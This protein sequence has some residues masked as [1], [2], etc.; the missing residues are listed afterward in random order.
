MPLFLSFPFILWVFIFLWPYLIRLLHS[1]VF[2]RLLTPQVTRSTNQLISVSLDGPELP[3]SVQASL[4]DRIV[5]QF[6][7]DKCVTG[8]SLSGGLSD[9][10]ISSPSTHTQSLLWSLDLTE[11]WADKYFVCVSQ[12]RTEHARSLCYKTLQLV[13][14]VPPL[15]PSPPSPIAR[16]FDSV[17][18]RK[19]PSQERASI[20]QYEQHP[21][22]A[23][24]HSLGQNEDPIQPSTDDLSDATVTILN[25]RPGAT[26]AVVELYFNRLYDFSRDDPGPRT[27]VY[28][29]DWNLVV[30]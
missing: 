16:T 17:K 6:S 25:S 14:N 12:L 22:D 11:V 5:L 9:Q 4:T 8:F 30:E 2:P 29:Q 27:V 18:H 21:D 3:L 23:K 7:R 10:V 20:Y 19:A 13:Q 15:S 1:L 24:F 26:T 28:D